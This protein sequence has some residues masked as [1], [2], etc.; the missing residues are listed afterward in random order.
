MGGIYSFLCENNFL[1]KLEAKIW[2]EI[3]PKTKIRTK[4]MNNSK[5]EHCDFSNERLNQE[6]KYY[7]NVFGARARMRIWENMYR[8]HLH[9]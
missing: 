9:V 1:I 3:F 2:C 7:K 5:F 6:K 8:V 4:T